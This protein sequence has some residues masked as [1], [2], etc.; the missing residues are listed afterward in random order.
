M[1]IIPRTL[2]F[3]HLPNPISNFHIVLTP[4]NIR[5]KYSRR[6]QTDQSDQPEP[7]PF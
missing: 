3:Q 5:Q 2:T 7:Y 1:Q 6:I 4:S